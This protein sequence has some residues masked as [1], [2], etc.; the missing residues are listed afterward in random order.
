MGYIEVLDYSDNIY[1]EVLKALYLFNCQIMQAIVAKG[2]SQ[3]IIRQNINTHW[4]RMVLSPC[5]ALLYAV[6]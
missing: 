5:T 2:G 3:T 6:L 1:L 4:Q